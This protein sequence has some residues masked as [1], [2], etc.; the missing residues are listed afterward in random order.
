MLHP[1]HLREL[2]RLTALAFGEAFRLEHSVVGDEH[3]LLAL[4]HPS[5]DTAAA[6]ALRA[7]GVSYEVVSQELSRAIRE[8]DPPPREFDPE[9]GVCLSGS[10][11]LLA[12]TEG[13]AVGL[14]DPVPREEHLLL[15]YLWDTDGEWPL[16]RCGTTR[17]EV[18]ER[19]AEEGVALPTVP[20]PP[21]RIPPKGLHQRVDVPPERLREVLSALHSLL[22]EESEWGWNVDPRTDRAWIAGIGEFDLE[23]RVRQ[24]L[25]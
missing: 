9:S 6:R 21:T 2:D 14:G 8:S 7:G 17:Q 13:L 5:Q 16:D 10:N 25:G 18:Y 20:L 24:A 11:R 3:F 19:L 15:A 22:P 4:L 12:R 1:E 23:E